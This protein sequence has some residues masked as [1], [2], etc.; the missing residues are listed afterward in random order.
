MELIKKNI[1]MD[2]ISSRG[3]IQFAMEEDVN[4]SDSKP[5]VEGIK[6]KRAG[7]IV[8]ETK[9]G[10]DYCV[11]KGRMEYEILYYTRED[12]CDLVFLKGMLPFEERIN[13]D[14]VSGQDIVVAKGVVENLDINTINSRKL[15]IRSVVCMEAW[16]EN[17]RDENLPIDLTEDE[18]AE[19][20]RQKVS[21]THMCIY[22]HD[23]LRV[24]KEI[25]LP[26]N[27][28]NI[29][30]V[31]WDDVCLRDVQFRLLDGSINVS[32]DVYLFMLYQGEGD[33]YPVCSYETMF[34]FSESIECGGCREN[35]ISHITYDIGQKEINI[36]PDED[37]E[38][39]NMVVEITSNLT[40]H[41]YEEEDIDY[42]SD[43]YGI[44]STINTDEKEA[45]FRTLL[46]QTKGKLKVT[47]HIN[48]DSESEGVMQLLHS[49]AEAFVDNIEVG[50]GNV[51]LNGSINVDSL[52]ITGND[53]MPYATG[54]GVLPFEYVMEIPEIMQD[55]SI[56]VDS[57]IEQLQVTVL[58]KYELDVKA[59]VAFETTSFR[60]ITLPVIEDI[61]VEKTDLAMINALPQIAVYIVQKNDNLWNIGKKYYVSVDSIRQLNQLEKDELE[62]GQKLLIA[63]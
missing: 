15:S 10:T 35:M 11:V 62:I 6:M 36:R 8:D 33:N 47:G 43:V 32:G 7:L 48:I 25:T 16:V 4:I 3:N 44:S 45:G 29:H 19:Y 61:T 28:L 9:P 59:V 51:L 58:D 37:G 52:Y 22:S 12:G 21:L 20:R 53:D 34:S 31:I 27:Y 50:D 63:R 24:K 56:D 38:D 49:Q 55:D 13:M 26:S 41:L 5:D 17:I 39:R 57:Y 23:I 14:G 42:V 1:H 60:D 54:T 18:K 30:Q 40:L 2:Q 46:N